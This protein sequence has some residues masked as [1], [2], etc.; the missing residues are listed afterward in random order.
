M[1]VARRLTSEDFEDILLPIHVEIIRQTDPFLSTR[2]LH[3]TTVFSAHSQ[4][5]DVTQLRF[6]EFSISTRNDVDYVLGVGTESLKTVDQS[7]RRESG[8]GILDDR[9]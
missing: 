2:N 4:F 3:E 1:K 7:G 6:K 9:S 5:L 8:R